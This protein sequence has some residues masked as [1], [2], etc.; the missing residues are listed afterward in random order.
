MVRDP[1]TQIYISQV[2]RR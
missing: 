1:P 2:V